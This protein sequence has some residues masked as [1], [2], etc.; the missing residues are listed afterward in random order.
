MIYICNATAVQVLS[1]I[2]GGVLV[3][4]P[5]YT[6]TEKGVLIRHM[7]DMLTVLHSYR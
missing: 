2:T 5:A 3:L 4:R 1:L 7:P 6:V